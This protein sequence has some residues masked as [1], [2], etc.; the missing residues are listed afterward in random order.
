MITEF[1]NHPN[2]IAEPNNQYRAICKAVYDGDTY[3]ML[4]DLGFYT[5]KMVRVR[6]RGVDTAELRESDPVLKEQAYRA[7][8]RVCEL[9]LDKYCL[10]KTEKD[11][12]SFDRWIADVFYYE[13]GTALP[14]SMAEQLLAEGLAVPFKK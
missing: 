14:H 1:T 5:F 11:H 10:I 13:E 8:D 6:L 9:L 12:T 4:V 7:R 2:K 3:T